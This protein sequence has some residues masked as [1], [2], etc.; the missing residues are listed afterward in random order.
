MNQV[1]AQFTASARTVDMLGRQQIAGIPNAISE[2]FKNAYDAYADRVVVEYYQPEHLLVLWDNGLGMTRED[3]EQKWL[4]LGTDSKVGDRKG[5]LSAI[6][7]ELGLEHRNTVG[8]KGIGRLAIGVIG[9]QVLLLSRAKRVRESPKM[10]AVFVNWSLFELPGVSLNEIVVPLREFDHGILPNKATVASMVDEVRQNLKRLRRTG[11]EA[12]IKEIEQQLD[13][14][15]FDPAAMQ[16]R[17]GDSTLSNAGFGT[18]FYIHPVDSVLN[19]AL[20]ERQRARTVGTRAARLKLRNMLVGFTN[21]MVHEDVQPPISTEFYYYPKMDVRVP[22]IGSEEFFTPEEF[23]SADH[24]ISGRFDERGQF[25]GT[26]SV[27]GNAVNNHVISWPE[28]R[29][30]TADCG[31]FHLNLAYVQGQEFETRMYV[32]DWRNLNRKLDEM[33]G[34]YIYRNG[35]RILPYGDPDVD[36][37]RFEERRSRRAATYFFSYRRMFGTIE[38]SNDRRYRLQEKAG[39]EGFMENRAFRQFRDILEHFFTQLAADFFREDSPS[40]TFQVEREELSRQ[41]K[42]ARLRDK[43]VAPVRSRFVRE[44]RRIKS[45]VESGT[46]EDRVEE[47]IERLGSDLNNSA[48]LLDPRERQGAIVAASLTAVNEIE[49]LRAR[50]RPPEPEGFGANQS[51]RRELNEYGLLFA[52]KEDR[53]LR[54]ASIRVE[55]MLW[56]SSEISG[57]ASDRQRLLKDR[58]DRLIESEVTALDSDTQ[59]ASEEVDRVSQMAKEALSTQAIELRNT[60]DMIVSRVEESSLDLL[61]DSELASLAVSMTSEISILSEA[62]HRIIDDIRKQ[63]AIVNVHPDESGTLITQGDVVGAM[64][65]DIDSLRHDSF[66]DLEYVQL[67]MTIGIIDHELQAVIR[68]LRLNLGRLRSWAV[69]NEDLAEVYQGIRVNFDHLDSYLRLLTPLQRRSRR[70]L[71]EIKGSAIYNFIEELFATRFAEH[72]IR[73]EQATAFEN[74]SLVSYPST[75]YPVF[76]NLVDN[77]MYWLQRRQSGRV[78]S[79]DVE[80]DA[81]LVRDNGP[82]ISALDREAV[83]EAGFTRK[84]GGM[85]L[86]LYIAR[87]Q[88]RQVNYDIEILDPPNGEGVTF[89]IAPLE[90]V[91][92]RSQ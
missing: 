68:S 1:T 35:I 49:N 40:G 36:F 53:V 69:R 67:G 26:V 61:S 43:E 78:I 79:F 18:Q 45:D 87:S 24:H 32:E 23:A 81:L 59:K 90:A 50:Y 27:Y 51:L 85:G 82:G 66:R 60:L 41:A 9:P 39:R 73:L 64:E 44:L 28:G 47:V 5:D 72:D 65:E 91:N 16:A 77:A 37:L 83:F 80:G 70:T 86:G 71:S 15:D 48:A 29:G 11:D 89:R 55:E 62:K 54:P 8:E 88:L 42:A 10:V 34:L 31:P 63:F 20:E 14:F 21:T 22:I 38:L 75:F 2:L 92:D 30:E 7:K 17:F 6:A 3:I 19:E 12:R 57:L 58:L 33:G 52:S 56:E 46:F 76:I 74:Y 13:G 25:T 4:V 84:P